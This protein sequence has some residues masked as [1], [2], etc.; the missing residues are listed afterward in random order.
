MG[1]HWGYHVLVWWIRCWKKYYPW[2]YQPIIHTFVNPVTVTG[3]TWP[4][5]S[6]N[7]VNSNSVDKTVF[8]GPLSGTEL[9]YC[10]TV[11]NSDGKTC[12]SNHSAGTL[13]NKWFLPLS[14][15]VTGVTAQI[16]TSKCAIN[17][18][19]QLSTQSLQEDALSHD[20]R[21]NTEE[22]SSNIILIFWLH[23]RSTEGIIT[24]VTGVTQ[25][26]WDKHIKQ[27]C[28]KMNILQHIFHCALQRVITIL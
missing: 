21:A 14:I 5:C 27:Y 9:T 16:Y 4:P 18:G 24:L 6:G 11:T 28:G 23:I 13:V 10:H 7:R 2:G 20:T 26:L 17:E 1:W 3:V 22:T 8:R 12:I 19:T 15:L 25:Y